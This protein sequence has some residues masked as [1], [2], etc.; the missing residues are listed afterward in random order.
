MKTS[1]LLVAAVAAAL[2][3]IASTREAHAIGPV[4]IEIA[5]KAGYGSQDLGFGLG[6]RAGVSIF[7]LYGG[8]NL[9]EYLGKSQAIQGAPVSTTVHELQFGGEVGFGFK[10]A[11]LTLRPLV[12]FGRLGASSDLGDTSSF[13]L[14]PGGLVQFG[15]GHLIF[16][17]DAG[18]L[19]VTSSP[20]SEAFTMHGQIG[21]RF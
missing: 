8:L 21:A 11:F 2:F 18:C 20:V 4:D 12:G 1:A 16:G 17:V 3:T 13:Y 5:G 15:F 19:I 9:V 7:G 10:I 6:A 14:E